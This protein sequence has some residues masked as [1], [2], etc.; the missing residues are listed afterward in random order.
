MATLVVLDLAT[1]TV[2]HESHLRWHTDPLVPYISGYL[3]FRELPAYLQLLEQA[4]SA[5]VNPQVCS[6]RAPFWCVL[7]VCTWRCLTDLT[8]PSS[9]CAQGLMPVRQQAARRC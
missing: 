4:R 5:N 7:G 6:W 3:A 1:M 9:T 2:T 8:A